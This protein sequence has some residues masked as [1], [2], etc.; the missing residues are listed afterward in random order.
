M[1][2]QERQLVAE[3]FDRLATLER[4]RRDPEAEAAIAEGLR[5]APNAPYALVQTVLVQDEALRAADARIRELEGGAETGAGSG[6]FLDS[7]RGTFLGRRDDARGSV[8]SIR[9]DAGH[10]S[11]QGGAPQ[12]AQAQGSQRGSFLG[13]AAAA[14]AGVIGGALLLDSFRSMFGGT[15]A[16]AVGL[17]KGAEGGDGRSPWGEAS[18]SDLARD[19]GVNDMGSGNRS[20]AHDNGSSGEADYASNDSDDF[21]ADFGG[22]FDLG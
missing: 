14:A 1:T 2:P 9:R 6:G 12:A 8:P 18:N 17:D 20:S 10:A 15:G 13:T 7:M 21:D 16:Q 3:L 22:D 19:A 11:W 4:N 5:R